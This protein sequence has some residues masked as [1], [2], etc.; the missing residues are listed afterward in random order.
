MRIAQISPLQVAVPPHNYGGTERVVANL[1]EALVQAG[2][3]VTLFASG[4]SQTS[5]RLISPV[6]HALGFS[7]E[8]DAQAHHIALLHDIFAYAHQ[9]DIIHSHL[10]YL[11]LPFA[12]QS[13]TPTVITLHGR[14][15]TESYRRVFQSYPTVPLIAISESQRNELA[16]VNWL[17]TIHHS[18][19]VADF[20][21]SPTPGSYLA[22]VGRISPE[23]RPDTAIEVAKLAGIPLIIAA[24]VDPK[25]QKYFERE[26][27]PLLDH[28]LITY[29]G[30]VDEHT[31]RQL[32][33]D[34]LAL[35]SPIDWPEPFGMVFIESLA[36]GTPVLT[37]PRGSAPE[38]LHDGVTGY[39]RATTEE[40][41]EAARNVA[42]VS[43]AGCRAY[44]ERHFSLDRMAQ[45]YIEA[46]GL[47]RRAA[48]PLAPVAPVSAVAERRLGSRASVI[49]EPTAAGVIETTG[50]R[51]GVFGASALGALIADEGNHDIEPFDLPYQASN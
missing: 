50:G 51:A 39:I 12:E 37:C 24:K 10:D 49:A 14:L 18:V 25:D 17:A 31:K 15:D 6:P 9:F 2:H 46:Y 28:P 29:V 48:L 40:L 43:R 19:D 34:S 32:M 3:D 35:L 5:A 44:A 22:F 33:R 38:L 36:S 16:G 7:P 11:T 1:T 47:A 45:E 23:K 13:A 26:V 30:V 21:Y 4:D 8:V 41:A 27:K 42:G 20:A